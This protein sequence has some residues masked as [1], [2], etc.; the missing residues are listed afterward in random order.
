MLYEAIFSVIVVSHCAGIE[1]TQ[2]FLNSSRTRQSRISVAISALRTPSNAALFSRAV[3]G[4][5][6]VRVKS[7]KLARARQLNQNGDE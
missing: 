4:Q 7:L 5:E 1:L 2:E 6:Q 3:G